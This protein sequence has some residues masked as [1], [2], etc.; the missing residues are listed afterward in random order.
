MKVLV[1]YWDNKI[2]T[3][4]TQDE[5][6]YCFGKYAPKDFVYLN[7]FYGVPNFISEITFDAII[8]HY[9]F[10]SLKFFLPDFLLKGIPILKRLKGHKIAIPQD[11]YINTNQLGKFFKEYG[12]KTVFTCVA[13]D[14]WQKVYPKETT[15]L[16]HYARVMTGYI[17]E[18]LQNKLSRIHIAHKARKYDIGHRARKVPLYYGK[19]VQLKWQITEKFLS[20]NNK[21]KLKVNLSNDPS[22]VFYGFDWYNFLNDCRVVLGTESGV[23]LLDVN[24]EIRE[25]SIKYLGSY[26]KATYEELEAACF[27]N[28]DGQFKLRSI[29]PRFLQACM[30]KTCQALIEGQYENIGVPGIHYISIKED[31]SNL[32][33][34]FEKIKD[35]HYC[36]KIAKQAYDDIVLSKAYTYDKFVEK[37]LNHIHN[38]NTPEEPIRN[39]GIINLYLSYLKYRENFF[40]LFN[41]FRYF[42]VRFHHVLRKYGVKSNP[43]YIKI[44]NSI[45]NILQNFQR[46]KNKISFPKT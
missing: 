36:E 27:K 13:K 7:A 38:I 12:V 15:G 20:F 22:E 32:P 9:T 43:N 10:L 35:I 26:P 37:I 41:L 45:K 19:F 44:T 39:R 6:I 16:L 21:A 8:Y 42:D 23:S 40:P 17:D 3:R 18:T 25:K 2:Q 28:M 31:F 46:K 33:E 24:G 14:E 29:G 30:T 34:V 5:N 11:E 1:I 4:S